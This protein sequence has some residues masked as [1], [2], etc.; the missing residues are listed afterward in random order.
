M[1]HTTRFPQGTVIESLTAEITVTSAIADKSEGFP[2]VLFSFVSSVF[3][4]SFFQFYH[5]SFF[6]FFVFFLS[7]FHY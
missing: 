7:F 1:S 5:F 2:S 3:F 4:L 6:H